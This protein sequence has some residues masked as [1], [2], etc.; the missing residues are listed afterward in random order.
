M[1][2]EHP[3]APVR[4]Q[5]CSRPRPAEGADGERPLAAVPEGPRGAVLREERA[6]ALALPAEPRPLLSRVI[7]WCT[8]LLCL[9]LLLATCGQ[10][11]NVY[12]L[13]QQVASQQQAVKQ[14]ESQNRQLQS[15]IQALQDPATIEQ[16]ARRL[17]YIYPGDQPVVV[18]VSGTL[19]PTPPARPSPP[20]STPWGFWS[21]WF[22]FFFGG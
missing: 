17:G 9:L 3:N 13:N 11:W 14:L 8:A 1:P 10:A 6:E 22:K 15:A 18:I 2:N 7:V 5:A 19:P 12:G 21:D 4:R 20:P 16:E